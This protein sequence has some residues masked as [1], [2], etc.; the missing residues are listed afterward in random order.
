MCAAPFEAVTKKK[1]KK[2]KEARA[3][4][5]FRKG[6]TSEKF[7]FGRAMTAQTSSRRALLRMTARGEGAA[8]AVGVAVVGLSRLGQVCTALAATPPRRV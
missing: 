6:D 8:E 2:K 3:F 7:F 5:A 4:A 1:D